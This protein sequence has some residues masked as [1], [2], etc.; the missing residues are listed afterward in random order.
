M[1]SSCTAPIDCLRSTTSASTPA[2]AYLHWCARATVIEAIGVGDELVRR[3]AMTLVELVELAHRDRWRAGACEATWISAFLREKVRSP[4]ES[5]ARAYLL[6]GGLPEPEVNG[7]IVQDGRVVTEADLSY[8]EYATVA[9]YDGGH[10]QSDRRQYLDDLARNQ[11]YRDLGLECGIVTKETSPQ[12]FV[13]QVYDRIARHGFTGP[14]PCFGP[15][16]QSLFWPIARARRG[17]G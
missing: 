5:S 2:S 8:R 14:P 7:L 10:H 16:W 13:A 12:R 3:G 17:G 6:F 4:Q 15:R 1:G 11:D 9:E